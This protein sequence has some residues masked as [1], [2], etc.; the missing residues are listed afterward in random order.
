MAKK[1]ID[2][3]KLFSKIMAIILIAAMLLGFA[4]SAIYY[5]IYYLQ[6]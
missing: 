6:K 4:A 5:L 2:K 3:S 1:K